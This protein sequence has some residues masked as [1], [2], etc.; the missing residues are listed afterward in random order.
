MQRTYRW[1]I[2]APGKIAHKFAAG[3]QSVPRAQ[4]YAVGSR[5]QDRAREFAEQYQAPVWYD[6]YQQLAEDPEVDA[7][8]IA[9]PHTFHMENTLLCLQHN[10]AVL[11]ETPLAMNSQQVEMM[12]KESQKSSSFLM[13]ALWS[14]FLPNIIEAKRLMDSGAIGQVSKMVADFGFKASFDPESRLFNPELG[15]GALL[16]I[17]IY[18]LFFAT[19]LFGTPVKVES[20]AT[21][22]STGVDESCTVGLTFANGIVADLQFTI[23]E[24]TPVEARITGDLGEIMLPNRWYQPVNIQTTINEQRQ[25]HPISFEG[26]GYNYQVHEVH[27]CLDE[28][29]IESDLWS[30]RNSL[31]LMQLMDEIRRQCG[32]IYPADI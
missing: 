23:T 30:H 10:K 6:S 27:K 19:F 20:T 12:I 5:N 32:I 24:F 16:D 3:L 1:G 17:G 18:P 13:E 22:G 15:G 8:Y 29:R 11:W 26:N 28:N 21:I 9:T 2:L 31:N 4:L 25:E 7:I 14:R